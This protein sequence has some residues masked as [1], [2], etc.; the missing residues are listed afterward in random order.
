MFR[1]K[2]LTLELLRQTPFNSLFQD[3][4]AGGLPGG[5]ATAPAPQPEEFEVT[6]GA[7]EKVKVTRDELVKGYMRQSDYTRK[8]QEL[9]RQKEELGKQPTKEERKTEYPR[10]FSFP[11]DEDDGDE[12]IGQIKQ[13][14]ETLE[15]E[16][17]MLAA[18]REVD[19]QIARLQK[20]YGDV[21]G[22]LNT[23]EGV[24]EVIKYAVE[25]NYS[26]LDSAYLELRGKGLITEARKKGQEDV[27]KGMNAR[28]KASKGVSSS[29]VQPGQ[30][31]PTTYGEAR[32]RAK[33]RLGLG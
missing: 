12:E 19:S 28:E 18:E 14:V 31:Y 5:G 6:L 22:K 23:E 7:G 11:D 8:T 4:S 9:A 27:L 2:D 21:D 33:A 30:T 16:N 29:S 15:A 10:P 25:K 13:R 26:K 20:E 1:G 17:Q 24:K 32:E 3:P